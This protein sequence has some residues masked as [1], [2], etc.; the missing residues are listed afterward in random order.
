MKV[1]DLVKKFI[2][3]II[4]IIVV[5]LAGY[6][7]YRYYV[8]QQQKKIETQLNDIESTIRTEASN[9]KSSSLSSSDVSTLQTSISEYLSEI[10]TLKNSNFNN[11]K[12]KDEEDNIEATLNYLNANIYVTNQYEQIYDEAE[13]AGTSLSNSELNN[14]VSQCNDII[15][16][17]QI[18]L[19]EKDENNENIKSILNISKLTDAQSII[20]DLNNIISVAQENINENTTN[21][22]VLM[23]NS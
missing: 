20:D 17:S 1:G 12:L 7:G 23:L 5:I 15:N 4:V 10:N 8:Y 14:I 2:V 21:E 18:E 6:F 9:A 22:T 11:S 3:I 19:L 16:S 13:E